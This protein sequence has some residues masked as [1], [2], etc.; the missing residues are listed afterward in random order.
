MTD[1]PDDRRNPWWDPM[2]VW[3]QVAEPFADVAGDQVFAG[4]GST[5]ALQALVDGLRAGLVGRPLVLGTGA[6]QLPS[7][8]PRST[9]R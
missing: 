5:N 8:S 9:R 6:S 3:Q 2:G 4:W 1:K 7:H